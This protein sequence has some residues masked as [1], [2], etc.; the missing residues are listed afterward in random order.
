MAKRGISVSISTPSSLIY[1]DVLAAK[2]S[3]AN[4]SLPVPIISVDFINT[5]GTRVSVIESQATF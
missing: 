2:I 1:Y 4:T 3:C 5:V